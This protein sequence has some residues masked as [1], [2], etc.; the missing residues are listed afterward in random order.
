MNM[1]NASRRNFALL[2]GALSSIAAPAAWP[3]S[4]TAGAAARY[5]SK[6]IRVVVTFPEAG[7]SGL[8]SRRPVREEGARAAGFNAIALNT[9][10]AFPS[11][12]IRMVVPFAAGGGA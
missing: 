4:A 9:P 11:K 5:P 1:R 7:A 8:V 3:Q 6:P 2:I 10:Q 12:P